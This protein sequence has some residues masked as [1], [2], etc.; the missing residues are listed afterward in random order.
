MQPARSD[1]YALASVVGAVL[2]PPLGIVFGRISLSRTAADPSLDGRGL[3]LVGF[4]LGIALTGALVLLAGAMFL[5]ASFL[6]R[7]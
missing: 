3:A 1:P 6:S 2:L 5:M 4:W 7:A